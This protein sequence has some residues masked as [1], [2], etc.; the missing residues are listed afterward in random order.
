MTTQTATT[1]IQLRPDLLP[2]VLCDLEEF[3][4]SQAIESYLVGGTV[5]DNLLGRPTDDVDIAVRA[6]AHEVGKGL[7]DRMGGRFVSLDEGFDIA[8]VVISVEGRRSYID[9]SSY[10]SDISADLSRR[11]FTADAMAVPLAGK[12][13]AEWKLI[14]PHGGCTDTQNRVLRSVSKNVFQADPARLMRAVRLAATLKFSLH[15]E[16]ATQIRVDSH[17]VNS[18]SPE[19]VREELLKTLA[20]DGARDSIRLLDDLG[21]LS[22]VIPE[23]EET[24]G[25]SQ[26]K[27]HHWNVFDHMVETVNYL[28]QILDQRPADRVISQHMPSFAGM[29]DHFA[30]E[31][32]DGH[33]RRTLLKLTGLLHDIAKPR[34]KTI[35]ESGRMRFFGHSEEGAHIVGSVL[36]RLRFGK[37]GIRLVT[38]MIRHHLR[39]TQMA[40]GD[41]LPTSRAVNRYFRDLGEAALDTL[42]LNMADFLGARGPDLTETQMH[43]HSKVFAHILE[44]GLQSG[45]THTTAARLINGNDIMAEFKLTP[46]PIVGQLLSA[47]TEAEASSK[48]TTREEALELAGTHL[49]SGGTR[50]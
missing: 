42:Y 9:L 21:L 45:S 6:D 10:D 16:T 1:A 15:S 3:L 36:R 5:R 19:R 31:V 23:L 44:V 29:R 8:R 25:V 2:H 26:P 43:E 27:E 50:A 48:L 30:E 24:R 32:S 7:A 12:H 49:K 47:V 40:Q 46:G 39:P 41:A 34:T 35:E 33:N 13:N 17:M 20:E 22:C 11:D 38:T 14:D 4:H 18:V 28:E 37:R